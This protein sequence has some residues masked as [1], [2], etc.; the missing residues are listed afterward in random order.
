MKSFKAES[1][2]VL[3]MMINSI[4][5]RK[6]VFLREL[7]SNCNDAIDKLYYKS[8]KENL[9]LGREDFYIRLTADEAARTLTIEDNGIGMTEKELEDNLGVIA[10]SGSLDFKK[11]DAVKKEDIEIIGQF[12]VGFYSCFMVAKKVTVLT[13]AYG[14]DQ[15]YLWES[16]GAEGYTVS[17]AQ[18]D[19]YGTII[20]LTMKEDT[21]EESY[22]EFLRPYSVE[23]IVKRYSDYIRYPIKMEVTET[24]PSEKEG[25]TVT[26][27]TDKTLNSMLP[28]W[29]KKKGDVTDEEYQ[30]F[31]SDKFMDFEKPLRVVPTGVEGVV[32]YNALLFIPSHAP[33]N[34][35]SKDYEKGLQLYSDSVLIMDK[36]ADLL[37]DC[38]S[39]VKGLVDTQDL[40]LNVSREM[41]QQDRG[42]K[43]IAGNLEKKIKQELL[44]VQEE[45]R[46][47]YEKF[48]KAFG[49]NLKF[50]LYNS[51]GMKKDLLQ[52]L[53][54]FKRLSDG[55]Y[56]TLKEYRDAMPDAQTAIYYA[57]GKSV[58]AIGNLPQLEAVRETGYDTLC[59]TDD[60]DEFV[61]KVIGAYDGKEFKNVAGDDLS[62][63]QKE[64]A[65]Q[66]TEDNKDLLTAVK[67]AL[68]GK[69]KDVRISARLKKYPVCLTSEGAMSI[70]MEKVLNTMP[71]D[72]KVSAEKVLELNAEHPV[73][74]KL[75]SF[76]DNDTD[77][78]NALSKVLYV[79]AQLI[80]GLTP[81]NATEY[82]DLVCRLIG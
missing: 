46:E 79:Q 55:K 41:L 17:P 61:L 32:S 14:S 72:Q 66:K 39:F 58:E 7:I 35:Y 65:T 43:I 36:C 9:G 67:E 21:A 56:V 47:D 27:K 76:R 71:T 11:D 1:K 10:H 68:E 28:I 4:Y 57:C 63:G 2:K 20:T 16:N 33:Y 8:L 77:K 15:A 54:I 6:E 50:G 64:D 24:V 31:Y 53:L 30:S 44:A 75:K 62:L 23:G 82:A 51:Y 59:L 5:T 49:L 18:K 80:E 12:G 37:P 78:F 34:Y 22:Q 40:S 48:W 13:R 73:F 29:K 52:D 26:E 81:D 60:V 38:F 45:S 19:S 3:D 25:E 74:E 69:V 42:L 70:E